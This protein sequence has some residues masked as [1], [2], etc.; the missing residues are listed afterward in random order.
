MVANEISRRA[1]QVEVLVSL[2][3]AVHELLHADVEADIELAGLL[4]NELAVIAGVQLLLAK[5]EDA[6]LAFAQR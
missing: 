4:Q 6:G 5:L 1:C 2:C 3:Y